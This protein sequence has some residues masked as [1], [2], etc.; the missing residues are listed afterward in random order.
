MSLNDVQIH[1]SSL[2][3]TGAK[4]DVGVKIG[5][6]CH[7]GANV[8]LGRG[9]VLHSHAVVV[10]Y[11]ELGQNNQIYPFASVGT[12][13]QD[14]KYKGEATTLKIGDSNLIREGVTLQPGTV[15]GGG[16]TLIG[17]QNLFMAYTHVAHDCVVGNENILA[18]TAQ[19]AGHVV[20]GNGTI[21][22]AHSGVHQFCRVGD[23]GMSAA[24]AMVVQDVAP[25]CLVHGDRAKLAGL[26]VVA[27]KRRGF[28]PEAIVAV[29]AAYKLLFFSG[30][31]SIDE[32]VAK[33]SQQQL[34]AFPEVEK[35]VSF[36]QASKRGVCRPDS[37]TK[38]GE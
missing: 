5:P 6:F 7:V 13:P 38:E 22:S 10:G 15:Q 12:A 18:N 1:P 11:T 24:G 16:K 27:L 37:N 28:S 36:V 33:I 14:L 17:N 8:T 9:T 2:V 26:N 19:L 29:R 32:A 21:I 4:L 20:L 30:A 35:L 34:L 25:Y 23:Y 3:E 31:T